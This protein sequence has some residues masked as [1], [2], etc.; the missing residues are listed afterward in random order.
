LINRLLT[1]PKH[2]AETFAWYKIQSSVGEGEARAAKQPLSRYIPELVTLDDPNVWSLRKVRAEGECQ[3]G[4][5]TS[6]FEQIGGA[7]AGRQ[8]G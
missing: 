4:T 6:I 2:R 1:G 8:C 5:M 7:G 3:G